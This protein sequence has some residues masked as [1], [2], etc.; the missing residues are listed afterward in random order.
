VAAAGKFDCLSKAA[1]DEPVFV[2]LARDPAAAVLVERWANM[3]D[4]L[5]AF[6]H[7]VETPEEREQIAEARECGG[8]ARLPR[9]VARRARSSGQ[10]SQ[11]G[12]SLANIEACAAP[13]GGAVGE[14]EGN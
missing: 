10:A 12:P 14:T 5:I 13:H 1:D 9:R 11:K 4:E 8:D 2:L 3:R 7:C 6:S